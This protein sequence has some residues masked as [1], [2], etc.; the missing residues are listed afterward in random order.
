MRC[1]TG[2]LPLRE[3]IEA[4]P[5][6][7][8]QKNKT[9]AQL[10]GKGGS[11]G[12]GWGL[13][14][15]LWGKGSS[16]PSLQAAF[17]WKE[18]QPSFPGIQPTGSGSPAWPVGSPTRQIRSSGVPSGLSAPQ[19]GGLW[20]ILWHLALCHGTGLSPV[21]PSGVSY[22]CAPIWIVAEVKSLKFCQA[23]LGITEI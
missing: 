6:Y 16:W 12:R 3:G 10:R 22:L 13:F 9:S 14:V 11:S 23:S 15:C 20:L 21:N 1:T 18:E 19:R 7:R 5:S 8:T 2:P 17:V 4:A